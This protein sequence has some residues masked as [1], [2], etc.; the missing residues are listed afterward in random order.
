MTGSCVRENY[1]WCSSPT[2]QLLDQLIAG[3]SLSYTLHSL[4]SLY[5]TLFTLLHSKLYI[6]YTLHCLLYTLYT[7]L[8]KEYG[9]YSAV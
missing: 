9:V 5:F 2:E 1:S 4:H 3:Y 7:S 8:A 6:L